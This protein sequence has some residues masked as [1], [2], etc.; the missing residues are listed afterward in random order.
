MC[1]SLA[2]A[3][4]QALEAADDA[5]SASDYRWQ[6]VKKA[7]I[8]ASLARSL[9]ALEQGELLAR[10]VDH[11]LARP[12]QYP[13][14]EAHVAALTTLAPWLG[15]NVEKPVPA[16]SRWL[17]ACRAQLEALTAAKPQAPT[18]LRRPASLGCKCADCAELKRFL[19]DPNEEVHRFRVREDRRQHL[20][21]IIHQSHCDLDLKTER[22][23]TPYTLVCTKNEASF[24][25]K[26]KKFHQ[27]QEHLAALRA[28]EQNLPQ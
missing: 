23:G 21:N 26:S 14:T 5:A 7:E 19:S 27:D 3:T 4:L 16:L 22:Q 15:K 1:Q 2:R 20:A 18:D 24:Q 6:H 12:K 11:T 8:L 25:A 13:L 28:I 9:L 10:L 17:A